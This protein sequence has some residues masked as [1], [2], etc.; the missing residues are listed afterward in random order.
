MTDNPALQPPS[1]LSPE[2]LAEWRI[3]ALRM[4]ERGQEIDR[5]ALAAYCQAYGRWQQAERAL[6]EM[7]K[8]DG[9]TSGLLVKGAGGKAQTNPLVAVANKAMADMARFGGR[10][11]ISPANSTTVNLGEAAELVGK[12]KNAVREWIRRGMPA[13]KSEEGEYRIDTAQLIAWRE[14]QAAEAAAPTDPGKIEIE[15]A[16]RRRL[17]AIAESAEIDLALRRGDAVSLADVGKGWAGL[18]MAF[19]AKILA[20]PAKL[21]P[22]LVAETDLLAAR[23]TLEEAL[24]EALIE[25]ADGKHSV[26]DDTGRASR[27]LGDHRSNAAD[28]E[29]AAET[30]G[31]PVG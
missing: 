15:E 14:E 7:A 17:V 21:A 13:E 19:R 9:V 18:V 30:D 20:I 26:R 29:T 23:N 27:P 1:E 11:G 4:A 24:H 16:K 28:G 2:A 31:Q 6:G 25:L 8:R 3:V 12:S 22:M 10:L 5:P